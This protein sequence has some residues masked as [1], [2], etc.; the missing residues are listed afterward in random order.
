[1]FPLRTCHRLTAGEVGRLGAQP[2]PVEGED[3]PARG[4]EVIARSR[5][6]V[7]P[8]ASLADN[9]VSEARQ[10]APVAKLQDRIEEILHVARNLAGGSTA[11]T[12]GEF[13]IGQGLP[14]SSL[15]DQ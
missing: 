2:T 8:P 1:M 5:V 13:A 7:G 10:A 4:G 3:L 6:V 12:I 14:F 11:E 15:F 9:Q